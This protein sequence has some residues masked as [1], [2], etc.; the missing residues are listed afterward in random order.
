MD[1][2]SVI[3][4]A[5]ISLIFK[6][7]LMNKSFMVDLQSSGVWSKD[8]ELKFKGNIPM[9]T[10]FTSCHWEKDTYFAIANTNIWSYCFHEINDEKDM[11]CV[12]L[13][14]HGDRRVANRDVIFGGY[15]HGWT[16]IAIDIKL[17][18]KSFQHRTWNHFCWTYS[19]IAEQ[20]SLFH[21]GNLVA[22]ANLSNYSVHPI[23]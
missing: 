3:R 13:Y 23:I 4:I 2:K 10:E 15:F 11:K 16:D 14:Y 12:Q 1:E 22:A 21:N 7:V 17:R 20:S 6:F 8:E 5:H 19:S 9:L 18:V